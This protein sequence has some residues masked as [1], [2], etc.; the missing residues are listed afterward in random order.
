MASEETC[1]SP[2]LCANGCGFFARAET[3][4][5]CSQCYRHACVQELKRQAS[6]VSIPAASTTTPEKI[7]DTSV[8][9]GRKETSAAPARGFDESNARE[10][11]EDR[12]GCCNKKIGLMKGFSCRC[13]NVYCTKHRHP[14]EH[15]CSFDFKAAARDSLAKAN[16]IVKADKLERV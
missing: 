11:P 14:E 3:R 7:A 1:N 10:K 9:S 12:C 6:S 13:G 5:L 16:P 8:N 2:R 4:N 15:R